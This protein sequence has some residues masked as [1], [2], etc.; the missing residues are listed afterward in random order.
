MKT[1]F[2]EKAS[3]IATLLATLF[4]VLAYFQPDA[5][6]LKN[7]TLH[8]PN[9]PEK[10]SLSNK[11]IA[12]S[13]LN[14]SVI[15]GDHN[16]VNQTFEAQEP[17]SVT[18][19][20]ADEL[21]RLLVGTWKGVGRIAIPGKVSI[22][23]TGYD[24]LTESGHYNYTGEMIFRLIKNGKHFELTYSRQTAGLWNLN[25]GK[26]EI[27]VLDLKTQ[28]KDMQ[29]EGKSIPNVVQLSSLPNAPR[30]PKLEDITPIGASLEYEIVELNSTTLR[31]KRK[32]LRG[33]SSTYEG[34][35]N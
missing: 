2:L 29:I 15:Y 26:L 34:T 18:T 33:V 1:P 8:Y 11:Q 7:N 32:D 14:S 21:K 24:Q 23:D 17:P 4:A 10:V 30:I 31:L 16:V 3:W 13:K 20:P 22:L 12:D 27:V 28:L 9:A 35:R 5:L 19:K 25:G 6:G